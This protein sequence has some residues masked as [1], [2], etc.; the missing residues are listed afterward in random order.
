MQILIVSEMSTPYAIGG[1]EVR[2]DLLARELV[3]LGHDVTWVSMHQKDSPSAELRDGVRHVHIGPRI[4]SPPTRSLQSILHY[5]ASIFY[6]L[7]RHRFDVVDCQTYAPL[8][9]VWL[10]CVLTRTPMVATIHDISARG[11]AGGDQ[12]L[13][14]RDHLLAPLLE[15]LIYRLPYR[16]IITVS[17]SVCAALQR[18]MGVAGNRIRVVSNAVDAGKIAGVA[19]D[20]QGCELIF[21]GRLVPHKHPMDFLTVVER[22]NQRSLEE[23]AQGIRAKIVGNGPQAE[24]VRKEI[25]IRGLGDVVDLVGEIPDHE[26]VISHLRSAKVLVLPSTREGFGLVL[27]EAMACGTLVAAYDIPAVRETIGPELAGNLAP[28]ANAE[29][30]A[31]VVWDLLR[32]SVLRESQTV[33]GR[34]RA[35]SDFAPRRFADGIEEVYL[36]VRTEVGD[37]A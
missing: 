18:D 25:S 34:A 37:G 31:D 30:L 27:V 29:G 19:P 14:R 32:D 16:R 7:L 12:W 33:Y 20:P 5:M 9:S 1:G 15:K 21:V 8:P 22:L 28:P 13:F 4:A 11:A 26:G 35:L 3:G 24:E 2:Y 6:F 23:N 10:A 17:K 36:Q